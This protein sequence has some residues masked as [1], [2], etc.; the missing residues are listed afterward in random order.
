MLLTW[1]CCIQDA[2]PGYSASNVCPAVLI[3]ATQPITLSL[4]KFSIQRR[5]KSYFTLLAGVSRVLCSYPRLIRLQ[6]GELRG[7][8]EILARIFSGL[9]SLTVLAGE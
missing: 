8:P 4:F 9:L 7:I 6:K 5:V 1:P 2:S 3:C